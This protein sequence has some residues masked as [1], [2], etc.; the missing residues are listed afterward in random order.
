[1]KHSMFMLPLRALQLVFAL[2]VMGLSGYVANWYHNDKKE[3]SPSPVN[4]LIFS[5]VFT[6]FSVV[7]LEAVP[8]FMPK[9]ALPI[10]FMALELLNVLF[11]FAG[12]IALAAFLNTLDFCR[13]NV[14]SSA[15]ADVGMGAM[16]WLLWGVTAIVNALTM[17]KNGV[18]RAGNPFSRTANVV[19]GSSGN[20][21]AAGAAPVVAGSGPYPRPMASPKE[22]KEAEA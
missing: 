8:R 12:F 10:P 7:T 9:F 21:A 1:M 20:G 13:G 5:S 22:M 4:F 2:V 14:C 11:Y 6:I 19:N 15:Q 18:F 3:M 16:L 17:K